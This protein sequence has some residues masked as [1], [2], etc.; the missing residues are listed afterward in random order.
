IYG[1]AA[2]KNV[3]SQAM[4]ELVA[5]R[6]RNGPFK[7]IFDF[8]SRVGPPT[9]NRRSLETLAKAGAFDKL[10]PTPAGI[11]PS[12]AILSTHASRASEERE[13]KQ[14]NLFGG[15]S[16]PQDRPRLN[17]TAAWPIF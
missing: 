9:L 13:S 1:L 14:T 16:G 10:Y 5:E 12:A 17:T 11:L 8:A 6:E 7:D 15:A 3:G 2:I 4:Q